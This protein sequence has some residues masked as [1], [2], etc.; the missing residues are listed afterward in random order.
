MQ[1][2]GYLWPARVQ[3][4][5]IGLLTVVFEPELNEAAVAATVTPR[6]DGPI[7]SG[8]R[9]ERY[10]FKSFD[11]DETLLHVCHLCSMISSLSTALTVS[12]TGS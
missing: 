11:C 10:A 5:N 4:V 3:L 1:Y 6:G 12:A 9:F 7:A 2:R 8:Q